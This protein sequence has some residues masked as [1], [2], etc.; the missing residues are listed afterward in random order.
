MS[1]LQL[2]PRP[3]HCRTSNSSGQW[4]ERSLSSSK[5]SSQSAWQMDVAAKAPLSHCKPAYALDRIGAHCLAGNNTH[6]HTHT[7]RQ[8]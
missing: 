5:P 8:S 7:Q 3:L 1:T 2:P 6:A 4:Q